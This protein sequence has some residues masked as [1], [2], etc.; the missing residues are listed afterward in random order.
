MADCRSGDAGAARRAAVVGVGGAG[1][2][3]AGCVRRI[4]RS[5]DAV[6]INTDREALSRSDA[7]VRLCIGGDAES[8][9]ARGDIALGRRCA[10]AHADEIGRALAGHDVAFVVAGMGG[11]TGTGAAPVVAEIARGMGIAVASVLI[12]PFAFEK[13]RLE[14]AREGTAAMRAV[15][16]ATVAVENDALA[17]SMPGATV[18]EAFEAVGR[19]VA[20]FISGQKGAAASAERLGRT[21]ADGVPPA[22]RAGGLV[23]NRRPARRRANGRHAH[24]YML[25]SRPFTVWQPATD[26]RSR[27]QPRCYSR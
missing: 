3:V 1:C 15:C 20:A 10:L 12:E 24:D 27:S 26:S 6:A 14:A 5:A 17:G 9:G 11:G 2:N 21:C 23:I 19:S 8:G 7:D 25:T 13:G 16:P 4:L 18:S 22:M